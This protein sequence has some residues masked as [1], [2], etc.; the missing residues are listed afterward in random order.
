M[1]MSP[2][3]AEGKTVH[4]ATGE[5]CLVLAQMWACG[6]FPKPFPLVQDN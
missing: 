2:S 3:A 1:A 5:G 4:N 6:H